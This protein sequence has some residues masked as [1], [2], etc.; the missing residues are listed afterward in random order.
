M[1]GREPRCRGIVRIRAR[2]GTFDVR[3]APYELLARPPRRPLSAVFSLG[4]DHRGLGA[5]RDVKFLEHRTEVILHGLFAQAEFGADL[6]V[7]AALGDQGEYPI[8]LGR[9]GVARVAPP[10][11]AF[12][13]RITRAVI[14]GSRM[15]LPAATSRTAFT[16]P[17][18]SISFNR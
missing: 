1:D 13:S 18:P 11:P 10:P 16:K 12:T 14:A 15:D 7:R 17:R 6:L 4:V 2:A 5:A 3:S 9:Q 8:F